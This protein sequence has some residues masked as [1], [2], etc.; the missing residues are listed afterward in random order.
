ME[1]IKE[2]KICL[3]HSVETR[4]SIS[5]GSRKKRK[6]KVVSKRQAAGR[7]VSLCLMFLFNFNC[8]FL[9]MKL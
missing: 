5:Q 6:T 2:E 1:I 8:L 4:R 9:V 7:Y 3:G